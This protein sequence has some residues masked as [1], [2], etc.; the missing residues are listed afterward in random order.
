MQSVRCIVCDGEVKAA[1][2]V[3]GGEILSC[4]DCGVE[5]EVTAVGPLTVED[6]PEVQ[7]DWG[8]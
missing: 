6:A 3:M 4:P 7:A 2:D 5:L 1:D 8:E